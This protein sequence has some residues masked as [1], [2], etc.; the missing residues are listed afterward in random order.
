MEIDILFLEILKVGI[1][2]FDECQKNILF[3]G[4]N[5]V[6]LVFDFPSYLKRNTVKIVKDVK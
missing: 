3:L 5:E 2:F 6:Q 4:K 1:Y